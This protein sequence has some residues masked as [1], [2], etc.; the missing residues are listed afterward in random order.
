[1]N[2]SADRTAAVTLIVQAENGAVRRSFDTDTIRIGRSE[3]NDLVIRDPR[4]SRFHCRV[5]R[6]GD[7]LAVEDTGSRNG[8]RL[9]GRQ[10]LKEPL[11]FG[12]TILVGDTEILFGDDE[13]KGRKTQV[14]RPAER[15]EELL[16]R[17]MRERSNLLALVDIN[18]ALNSEIDLG[19]LL[20]TIID[21][22]IELTDAE[23]GFL[24][25]LSD[26]EM[27]FEVARNF[28]E[29]EV[30]QPELAVSRS[31]ASQVMEDLKPVMSINAREDERF[32]YVQS[33]SNLGLRSVL[34]VPLILR[35]EGLGAVYVDNRLNKGVFSEE[36]RAAVEAFADQAAIA[37]ENARH[38]AELRSNNRELERIRKELARMNAGLADTVRSQA[39]ELQKAWSA[40]SIPNFPS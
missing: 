40:S 11:S 21:A 28:A 26:G 8:T 6:G 9:N 35:G 38:V 31:I 29:T 2:D 5:V 37:L 3:Q 13:G 1:M 10:I 12:D 16:A 19:R 24:I 27:E 30:E 39:T 14:V 32:R 17:L 4:A 34:C 25:T 22:V 7:G 33:I 18:K 15:D 23:R 36:D 20:E